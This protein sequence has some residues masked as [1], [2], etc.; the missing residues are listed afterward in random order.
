MGLIDTHS[1]LNA[2]FAR[3]MPRYGHMAFFSQSGAL[4]QAI[5][6]WALGEGIGFSRFISI[7]NKSDLDEVSMLEAL[8][9][10][11]HTRVILGYLE[12]VRDGRGFIEAASRITPT[13]PIILTK[14]G[15]TQAGA[16]AAASHT[17]ALTGSETAFQA[18][19]ERAGIHPRPHRGRA[20]QLRPGLRRS[21]DPRGPSVA[22]VTNAG[23]PAG[24]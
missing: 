17:G 13:K 15:T 8:A 19:C 20:V 6:D 9:V 1:R 4:C 18:A 16:R 14:S 7:G 10:D 12:S 21:A 23:G 11:P 3:G 2:T 22:V 5:I 24:S